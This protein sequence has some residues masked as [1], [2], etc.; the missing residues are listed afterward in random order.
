MYE[1]KSIEN[2]AMLANISIAARID[3]I[4]KLIRTDI[5][6]SLVASY[7]TC[8]QSGILYRL[9]NFGTAKYLG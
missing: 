4:Y 7:K 9:V 8:I 5:S 2:M 1:L 3:W 6:N